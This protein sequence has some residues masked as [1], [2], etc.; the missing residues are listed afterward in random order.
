MVPWKFRTD[1]EL[2]ELRGSLANDIPSCAIKQ[3]NQEVQQ[4]S[5]YSQHTSTQV[6]NA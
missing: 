3:A 1:N 4:D 5:R 2:P 6:S